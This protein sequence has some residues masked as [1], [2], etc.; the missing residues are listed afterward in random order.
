MRK[1]L[2]L[3]ALVYGVAL[4][5]YAQ[6][7]FGPRAGFNY[8]NV[9]CK[10]NKNYKFK[11]GYQGGLFV[12]YDLSTA[13][14]LQAEVNYS[15]KGFRHKYS[16]STKFLTSTVTEDV[17]VRYDLA[18]I[19]LP[20]QVNIK[21]G[22]AYIGLGPQISWLAS[23]KWDGEATNTTAMNNPPSTTV[24]SLTIAGKDKDPYRPL[25]FGFV[26]GGGVKIF[27]G[28]EY[29]LRAGYGLA[30]VNNP[31]HTSTTEKLHNLVISAVVGYG[32]GRSSSGNNLGSNYRKKKRH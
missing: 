20:L 24:Y 8:T 22:A 25:D 29:G 28:F 10:G 27:N 15:L 11:P 18:Y 19:D 26:I 32:F 4:S 3:F 30:N 14:S 1:I 6:L 5:S 9:L 7:Y 31:N 12:E 21:F 16:K 23:A 17:D 2:I 13:L